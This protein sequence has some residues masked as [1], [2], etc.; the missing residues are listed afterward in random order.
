MLVMVLAFKDSEKVNTTGGVGPTSVAPFA[1]VTRTTSGG[2]VSATAAVV[3][4]LWK[5]VLPLPARSRTWL[6]FTRT[7]TRTLPGNAVT[8]VKVTMAPSTV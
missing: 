5:K 1:G 6:L 3:K 8:G 2:V 4:V 7:R